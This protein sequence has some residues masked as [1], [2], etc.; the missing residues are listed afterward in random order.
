MNVTKNIILAA[1]FLCS[2]AAS[3]QDATIYY[4]GDGMYIAGISAKTLQPVTSNPTLVVEAYQAKLKVANADVASAKAGEKSYSLA[5]Y[6]NEDH[7]ELD[8]RRFMGVGHAYDLVVRNIETLDSYMFGDH[9]PGKSPFQTVDLIAAYNKFTG[10]QYMDLGV[11]D[12]WD[13]PVSYEKDPKLD[14]TNDQITVN[15][16][17]PHEGLVVKNI[18]FPIVIAEGSTVKN[19]RVNIKAWNADHTQLVYN[20][21]A[22]KSLRTSSLTKVGEKDGNSVY[23]IEIPMQYSRPTPIN[24]EFEVTISGLAQEGVNAWIPRAVDTHNLYPSH[25]TYA[26]ASGNNPSVNTSSDV[27]V[28]VSG[29]FNYIGTWGFGGA[30][31]PESDKSPRRQEYYYGK[32]EYGE[33]VPMGDLVQIY[34]DPSDAD[35][36]GDYF[37]GE[38]SF[39]LEGT[40]GINDLGID[41]TPSW[42]NVSYDD[43][44]WAEYGALQIILTGDPLPSDVE[45]RTGEVVLCTTDKASYYRIK[46]RQ[47][48]AWFTGIDA[49]VVALPAK[50][51]KFDLMG[52]RIPAG[53]TAPVIIKDGKKY[54]NK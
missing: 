32:E 23:L 12:H 29:Y 6:F 13:C 34:Y 38:A 54:V 15:F 24:G 16:G 1:T 31:K 10:E 27:C 47:G 43:S 30:V 37:M 8:I 33:V 40:F 17:N 28:N 44:Q 52:R 14:G 51:G 25:T 36:P 49:P 2:V 46:V 22:N 53:K 20:Y 18:N 4:P 42:I 19:I 35:W 48:N 39:P 45:G 26:D 21:A 9:N 11:Y 3:A 7:T 41:S 5:S 50:G